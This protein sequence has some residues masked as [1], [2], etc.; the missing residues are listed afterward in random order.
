M[1]NA[2]DIE[3]QRVH[4]MGVKKQGSPRPIIAR[5]LRFTDRERVFRQALDAK[6]EMEVKIYADYPKEKKIMAKVKASKRRRQESIL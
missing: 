5:F 6:D 1:E 4:R 2:R 3:F